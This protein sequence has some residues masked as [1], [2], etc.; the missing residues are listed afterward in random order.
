[1]LLHHF[2]SGVF[3]KKI[4]LS[5]LALISL[6]NAREN[7]FFPSEGVQDLPLSSNSDTARAQLKRSA[8]T[9]PDSARILKQITIKYQNL[10]G[11]IQTKAIEL[12]HNVDWHIP[13]FISQSYAGDLESKPTDTSVKNLAQAVKLT[14]FISYRINGSTIELLSDDM[15]IRDFILINPHRIAIDFKRDTD[16]KSMNIALKEKPFSM[17]KYG[18]HG[19]YY[20]IVVVLDGKYRCDLVKHNGKITIDIR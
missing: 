15:V 8:I 20:R 1:M 3:V 9:L 19:S 12:D 11:S 18:N 16:V 10:D 2:N 5:L 13:I 14:D 6:I 7:P 4:V 17:I